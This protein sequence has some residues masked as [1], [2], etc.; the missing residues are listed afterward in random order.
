MFFKIEDWRK[1]FI[2]SILK[3]TDTV[4]AKN[5]MQ[6]GR[7]VA[8]SILAWVQKDNY[9]QSRGLPRF[10]DTFGLSSQYFAIAFCVVSSLFTIS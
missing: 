6:Y 1:V 7:K 2:D 8:D 4:I 9:N 5:S 10:T 3:N